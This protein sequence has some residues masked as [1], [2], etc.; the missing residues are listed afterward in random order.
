MQSMSVA[1]A[2]ESANLPNF[3]FSFHNEYVILF[4]IPPWFSPWFSPWFFSSWQCPLQD[5]F[6]SRK[7]RVTWPYH[8]NFLCYCQEIWLLPADQKPWF[9][10]LSR[11]SW[12]ASGLSFINRAFLKNCRMSLIA[13]T[14]GY[15]AI[16]FLFP[17]LDYSPERFVCSHQINSHVDSVSDFL[18]GP[19]IIYSEPFW[20]VS[21]RRLLVSSLFLVWHLGSRFHCHI[22]ILPK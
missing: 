18:V 11:T 1:A 8:F 19:S 4:P 13:G 16:P 3:M 6:D 10:I 12:L 17:L 15:M 14:M 9:M 2:W 21:N 7:L 20:S 22:R 5:I